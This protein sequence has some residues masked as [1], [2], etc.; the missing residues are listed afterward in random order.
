[1]QTYVV[2]L[3]QKDKNAV[4]VYCRTREQTED[5]ANMLSKRG[6]NSMAYHGGKFVTLDDSKY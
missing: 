4:I 1:M 6:L 2:F 3:L 5:L